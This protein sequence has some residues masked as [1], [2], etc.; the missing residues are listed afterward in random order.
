MTLG[1]QW[2]EQRPNTDNKYKRFTN[3]V[4]SVKRHNSN[5]DIYEYVDPPPHLYISSEKQFTI[6]SSGGSEIEHEESEEV[7]IEYVYKYI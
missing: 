6:S 2:R 7:T 5:A 4:Y 1:K 3:G